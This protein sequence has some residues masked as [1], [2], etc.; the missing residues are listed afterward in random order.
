MKIK[1]S[2]GIKRSYKIHPINQAIV[3]RYERKYSLEKI[4]ENRISGVSFSDGLRQEAQKILEERKLRGEF[5]EE[6]TE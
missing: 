3:L 5:N 2:Y 6:K 4:V 1:R